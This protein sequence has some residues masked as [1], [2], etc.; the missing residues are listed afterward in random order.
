MKRNMDILDGT[1][2]T[3]SAIIGG[4][5]MHLDMIE[6]YSSFVLLPVAAILGLT[7]L[8]GVCPLGLNTQNL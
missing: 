8:V 6:G 5:L 4:L 2:R 7:S 1:I 3:I